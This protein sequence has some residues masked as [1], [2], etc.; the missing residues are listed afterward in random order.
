MAVRVRKRIPEIKKKPKEKT[1]EITEK[2]DRFDK[3]ESVLF[4]S[5]EVKKVLLP[6][7]SG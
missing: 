6:V 4:I 1:A 5:H 7:C 2:K 3:K